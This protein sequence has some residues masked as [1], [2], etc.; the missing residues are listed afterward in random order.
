VKLF[1]LCVDL[2][3]RYKKDKDS[4]NYGAI[5]VLKLSQYLQLKFHGKFNIVIG[6]AIVNQEFGMNYAFSMVCVCVL[7]GNNKALLF[8]RAV[9]KPALAFPNLFY[10]KTCGRW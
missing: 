9:R 8:D 6:N 5:K 4:K 3:L 10:H 7:E 1:F 2:F